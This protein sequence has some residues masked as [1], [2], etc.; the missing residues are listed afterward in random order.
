MS[1]LRLAAGPILAE[2]WTLGAALN[3]LF[4]SGPGGPVPVLLGVRDQE[5]RLASTA[6]LG[7]IVGP[8]GNRIAEGR[9]RLD[10]QEY[11]LERNFAQRHCL[12]SGSDGFHRREWQVLDQGPARVR[13][14]LVWADTTGDHPGPVRAEVTYTV[15]EQWVEHQIEVRADVTTVVNVAAHP[16]LNLAGSG[17]IHEH[18]LQVRAGSYL[19]VSQTLIPLPGAPA[20]VSG[21][22]DLRQPRPLAES[23]LAQGG[24]DHCFVLDGE[25]FRE[26][27][28]LT[29][30]V[31]GRRL[32]IA[33][34]RPG[35]QV[36]TGHGLDQTTIGPEGPYQPYAGVALETQDFPD[37]PNR[38]DFP[39]TVLRPGEVRR[40]RTRWTF[41]SG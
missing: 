38:P 41:S 20:P 35:L 14:G 3:G 18:L 17:T 4:V 12:H 2:V 21:V 1:I 33:T 22:F 32:T 29:D 31:S 37:A 8:Y 28:S 11:Q 39:S 26:V 23:I 25:G 16:Y 5:A 34:D 24:L 7:E 15:G 6:Y 40:S 9:F 19:P 30:P 27:A 13:L 36:Y 10:G